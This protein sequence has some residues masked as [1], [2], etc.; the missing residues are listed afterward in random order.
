[1][2]VSI[3]LDIEIS[4]QDV[5][6]EGDHLTAPYSAV[7]IEYDREEVLKQVD[8]K[9]REELYKSRTERRE[10][11]LSPAA[12]MREKWGEDIGYETS[13]YMKQYAEYRL[14]KGE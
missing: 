8:R 10:K 13:H 5:E 3:E 11:P 6:D 4:Y 1:M 12:W 14:M 7:E 2:K 9:V